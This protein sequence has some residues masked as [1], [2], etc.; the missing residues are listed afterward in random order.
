MQ[1]IVVVSEERFWHLLGKGGLSGVK[2]HALE[3]ILRRETSSL[4]GIVE[5]GMPE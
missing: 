1:R 4:K 3:G 2:L 5:G